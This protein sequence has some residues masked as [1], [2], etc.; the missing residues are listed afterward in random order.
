[1]AWIPSAIGFVFGALFVW[2]GDQMTSDDHLAAFGTLFTSGQKAPRD[3]DAQTLQ[4][5]QIE[6]GA[7]G[8]GNAPSEGLRHRSAQGNSFDDTRAPDDAAMSPREQKRRSRMKIRRVLLLV[9][10][11]TVHNF[12]EGMAVGFG[13]GAVPQDT[14]RRSYQRMFDKAWNLAI[15]I[16][17]Q[18]FPEGFAVSVPLY[19][20]GMSKYH[21]FL[22]GQASGM[23]EPIAGLLGYFLVSFVRALLPYALAFAAGAMIFV[24]C[25]DLL[26]EVH[27]EQGGPASSLA[28]WGVMAGFTVMMILDVALG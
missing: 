18:N 21:A 7:G 1:M 12:P 24:V 2:L 14:D 15:G 26:A 25:D 28:S 27:R 3:S 10:A 8:G 9:M 23:V 6:A 4:F 11:I 20:E 16:G 19:R 13:F 17:I 5:S 22:A